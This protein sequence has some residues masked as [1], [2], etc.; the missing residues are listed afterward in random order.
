MVKKQF[1]GS[2]GLSSRKPCIGNGD[3]RYTA[4][5]AHHADLKIWRDLDQD[6]LSQAGELQTL[7]YAGVTAINPSLI[8]G[9]GDDYNLTAWRGR[10]DCLE[11]REDSYLVAVDEGAA[12]VTDN[13]GQDNR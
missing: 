13:A 4:A 7:P 2:L 8:C 6:G 9:K 11:G 10:A 1:E 5:D 12:I 3:G